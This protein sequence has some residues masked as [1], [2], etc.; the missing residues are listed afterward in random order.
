MLLIKKNWIISFLNWDNTFFSDFFSLCFCLVVSFP[1]KSNL[2][3]SRPVESSLSLLIA[4]HKTSFSLSFPLS[5]S[6]SHLFLPFSLCLPPALSL[7]LSTSLS[8]FLFIAFSVYSSLIC[9]FLFPLIFFSAP[10][11]SQFF[12]LFHFSGIY[13]G[14]QCDS[15]DRW[16]CEWFSCSQT[17]W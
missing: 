1:V 17:S 4:L 7:S 10:I 9:F 12:T 11:S 6:P 2:V 16:R 3:L 13:E 8:L 5:L 15:Y 14:R